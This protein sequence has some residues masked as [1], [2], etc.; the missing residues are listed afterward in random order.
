MKDNLSEKQTLDLYRKAGALL[1]GHFILSS[2]LHSSCYLQSAIVLSNPIYMRQLCRSLAN[3]VR[4]K[5]VLEEIDLIVSPAVGGIVVGSGVGEELGIKSIFT[6]RVEGDFNLRRGFEIKDG[7]KVLVIEDVVTT[8][9]SSKE[10][11]ECIRAFNGV[12]IGEACLIDRSNKENNLGV[13]LVKLA[14]INAPLFSANEIPEEL[15][16]I[17]PVVPGSRK[18]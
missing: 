8:G 16:N 3:K 2:G 17:E 5:F 18:I 12:I 15:R 1:E 14:K 7:D 4:E 11:F 10:C 9:K 6:E 13:T